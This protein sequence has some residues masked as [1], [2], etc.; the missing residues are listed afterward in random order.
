MLGNTLGAIPFDSLKI[1][2][3]KVPKLQV[4]IE[5]DL[6]LCSHYCKWYEIFQEAWIFCYSMELQSST[7][8]HPYKWALELRKS[9]RIWS[10]SVPYFP[11]FGLN[12]DQS[13]SE[14]GHF[15]LSVA[16]V[17]SGKN[18]FSTVDPSYYELWRGNGILFD[19]ITFRSHSEDMKT[20]SINISYF[21]RL[22]SI[23]WVFWHF[24]VTKKLMTSAYNRCFQ[25]FVTFNILQIEILTIESNYIDIRLVLLEKW[26]GSKSLALLGLRWSLLLAVEC[27]YGDK[28]LCELEVHST[29]TIPA[30]GVLGA[31]SNIYDGAFWKKSKIAKCFYKNAPS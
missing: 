3:A 2:L 12:T 15:S 7:M 21:Q 6:S 19:M 4:W 10:Y 1:S 16:D 29:F 5:T 30:G 8:K 28:N 25:H 24:V 26:R 13:N 27:V 31:Q 20:F 18:F 23:F 14:Y 22:S 11:A 9:V 17:L